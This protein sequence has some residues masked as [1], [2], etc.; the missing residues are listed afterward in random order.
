MLDIVFNK[1]F[2][3]TDLT[4]FLIT[5]PL[6][7]FLLIFPLVAYYIWIKNK[8]LPV[9]TVELDTP[10]NSLAVIPFVIPETRSLI[11]E[12][13]ENVIVRTFSEIDRIKYEETD[14]NF[15]ISVGYT[16]PRRNRYNNI[17]P[18]NKNRVHLPANP[19]PI[20]ANNM[21]EPIYGNAETT[22]YI[23][24]SWIRGFDKRS[25]FIAAQGPMEQTLDDFWQMIED[26][27][28]EI[29]VMLTT[30]EENGVLKC[31]EY[32]PAAFGTKMSLKR[33]EIRNIL[34]ENIGICQKR[35]F[36]ITLVRMFIAFF[37]NVT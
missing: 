20:Y 6:L 13:P 7:G 17:M 37:L 8:M 3:G 25:T 32:F 19:E 4:I 11:R 26:N 36:K 9:T 10:R 28:V 12:T 18:Y 24:A 27:K 31:F 21:E 23:N 1:I 15:S 14:D 35:E 22:D 2:T 5:I 34:D 30:T 33:F 29:I 16:N